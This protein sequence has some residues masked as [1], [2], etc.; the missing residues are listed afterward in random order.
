[1]SSSSWLLLSLVAVT[2][3]QSLTEENAKTFLNNFNQEAEDLSYQ[4]SL[5]SWN[6]NTN[7]TEENA[8]KMSEAAAKWS[9]FY[10]EQSKTAQSFSLQEIQTPIIK[11]QL[12]ALQQSG[13]SALSADKN[14]QLNTILNT[15]STIYST[16]KVCNP[17]N[18]Q[19]CLLLEPGLDEIMATSTDYNSRLWAWEG[20]RAEVGKQLRPLYEEYVVLKNEMARA[21]NYNDYGDYWRGDYEAEGADGYN[22]NR[23]QLIEDV[24]RTFAEIK[25][26]YEHLHAY[27]RRKLMDTYP[28]YISPTGCLPAHLLGDMWGR[29]WTNLYPL[30]VPF[31]QKPNIDVTDAMMNQGWDAERIFQE[32]EKFFV[33]VGLPH[34]TQGFW[35]NSMLTEPADG[36]KVVCHPTAWDLGHGDFRIKMCT[37]VTMDNFLT[38]HHEMG[39]I[40]YD[41]A[42]ARQPFLL[43]N[44]ANEGFHEAVGEIM[45]LSAAT[46]KHLKSIGLLPS[47]F[48]EDSETEINFLLKQALTI[49]GTL[50]FTYMLEKWRW[51]VFRGEIPKE[52]WMKKWWEMKREIVGVVEP[53]PHD[54]TYCDP[55]SLFHVSNDYSFIRYYTRTIYQFQ[56][57]EALCQ[58]AK[59]NGS[60]HKCDISN[61]TEAGQK[62]L[63]MLSLGN[64]EPWTKALENVVGA[65]NMDVK[66][67][68]NYFQP[69][70][71]WLKEQNRNSFVGWNTEWSPY[72]D[73][74]IKVRISLKSA[75]GANAYEWT[76]NEMFLFRSSVAYA[77]RKYFSIIKNQTVPFLEEDVRVSDLKPRVSFYFFVTS[78]QN[79]SDVIP[80]SEVEDAIRM[81]RGRINDVFG[82]NDNSLE[83]LGIHPT[84]E[85]PYQPPVTIWLIIFGVVMALVVVGIIILIVTGIKGRK[86]KNETKR[87]E[88]PYDSMDIGKGES[89]AGFQNS[90]DA[91]TSF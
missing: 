58:A 12:Q 74:S 60:L 15:M 38:A 24:E 59:Y 65:R 2:T 66:P 79:V 36:R 55:A 69:L 64:S 49:V 72:A 27:V 37:K 84:L 35:A 91:Q 6:Y 22:Y 20:W 13:S 21:N 9:A 48:Q 67:L 61:S 75:L 3:A 34:M 43:R 89:N 10:E 90:D 82:L 70:F 17:K 14:K 85:P 42:Y 62:L 83:F 28:S 81:S 56:F 4:S 23:N 63:K 71:D 80:R 73:Q 32:A 68:L 47:D 29:F 78:P 18:P 44:G 77:M 45:S 1:M 7:I 57:Q 31:A 25:P 5:A 86:K 8:Q 76:N 26:L 54:E 88:N 50:P 11:R 87:E 39:H 16:G 19:E 30:T 52:Q 33:S 40:Q 46:P 41:M 53:L 51:M